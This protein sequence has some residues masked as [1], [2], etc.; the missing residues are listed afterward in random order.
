[1]WCLRG[2]R[3]RAPLELRN[4]FDVLINNDALS[5]AYM[6]AA[7]DVV[8][9]DNLNPDAAP[10][11]GSEDFADMLKVVPGAY[12]TIGH[13]GVMPLHNPQYTLD[14]SILPV[15]AA[16]MARVAERRLPLGG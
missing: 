9:E 6:D 3:W 16:I 13:A 12:C 15:G 1:M 5:D 7:R 14:T 2:R 11:T 8:G 4:V 10:V